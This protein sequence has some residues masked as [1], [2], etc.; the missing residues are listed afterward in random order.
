MNYCLCALPTGSIRVD[1]QH[2]GGD[3]SLP[4]AV[5]GVPTAEKPSVGF[6]PSLSDNLSYQLPRTLRELSASRLKHITTRDLNLQC[7]GC[8][9]K[10]DYV[11]RLHHY[12]STARIQELKE[13]LGRKAAKCDGCVERQQYVDR[14]LDLWA[15][16]PG[17]SKSDFQK[18]NL[19]AIYHLPLLQSSDI[20]FPYTTRVVALRNPIAIERMKECLAGD[21]QV[22]VLSDVDNIGTLAEIDTWQFISPSM[23][24]VALKGKSRFRVLKTNSGGYLLEG[25]VLLFDDKESDSETALV[26]RNTRG[27]DDLELLARAAIQMLDQD[28]VE[29]IEAEIGPV[30]SRDKGPFALSMWIAA[31]LRSK[32]D[33]RSKLL[34]MTDT[35]ARLEQEI[36][37]LY[38]IM[39]AQAAKKSSTSLPPSRNPQSA[40]AG[41]QS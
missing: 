32:S 36:A 20:L 1:W 31:A 22:G 27:Q 14:I 11:S 19:T 39:K 28:V 8:M 38:D 33:L 4:V 29:S 30:P 23:L 15:L 16:P 3:F 2:L 18:G 17:F 35:R 41:G 7:R 26:E 5:N 37:I 34:K 25:N 9:Q 12:L 13:Y 21:R 6:S 24:A 10:D 40:T